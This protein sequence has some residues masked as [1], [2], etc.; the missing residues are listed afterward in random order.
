MKNFDFSNYKTKINCHCCLFVG[1]WGWFLFFF[2]VFLVLSGVPRINYVLRFMN[3][4]IVLSLLHEKSVYKGSKWT[5]S[6]WVCAWVHSL[7]M[8]CCRVNGPPATG[9]ML[10]GLSTTH[11]NPCYPSLRRTRYSQSSV[12]H[13]FH[14]KWY[15]CTL[16]KRN[17][18]QRT[19][20]FFIE[21]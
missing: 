10:C 14:C 1:C 13:F 11:P 19:N 16:N 7:I 9:R 5:C 8:F 6:D 20:S 12:M 3:I 15:K 2:P 17:S 21:Q 4:K 18:L